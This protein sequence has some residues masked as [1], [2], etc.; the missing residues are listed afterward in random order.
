MYDMYG[1]RKYTGNL[2]LFFVKFSFDNLSRA[3][4]F[5]LFFVGLLLALVVYGLLTLLGVWAVNDI[6]Q[7]GAAFWNI[8]AIIFILA[9]AV[10]GT[11]QNSK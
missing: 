6:I 2:N 1:R 8:A 7:H 4:L 11:A 5:G 3:G 9:T 10:G